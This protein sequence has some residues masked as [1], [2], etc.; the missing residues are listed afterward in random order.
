MEKIS[1]FE[2]LVRVGKTNPFNKKEFWEG[3]YASKE[4]G[5]TFEWYLSFQEFESKFLK[6]LTSKELTIL[7]VGAGNSQI[8]EKLYEKAYKHITNID[9]SPSVVS[10]MRSRYKELGYDIKYEEMNMLKM[11]FS[12]KTFDIVLDLGGSDCLLCSRHP[13][14]DYNNYNREVYRLLREQGY[15]IRVSLFKD[16]TKYDISKYYNKDELD[17]IETVSTDMKGD[18]AFVFRKRI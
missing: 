16:L 5:E 1:D 11:N 18:R 13:I 14:Q 6:F 9:Y 10:S 2:K 15:L 4:Q 17:L 12:D 8:S 3:K 7:N